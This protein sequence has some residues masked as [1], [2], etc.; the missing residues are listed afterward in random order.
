MCLQMGLS[1]QQEGG[2]GALVEYR[3]EDEVCSTH[4]KVEVYALKEAATQ[5]NSNL[6]RAHQ[7][8]IV[9]C[10]TLCMGY[11]EHSLHTRRI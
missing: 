2:I 9:F 5:V 6:P 10:D 11:Y 1:L 8:V 7:K 4:Y 3:E